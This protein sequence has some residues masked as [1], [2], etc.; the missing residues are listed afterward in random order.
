M[1]EIF[2]NRIM[3]ADHDGHQSIQGYR[4]IDNHQ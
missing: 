4:G 2:F 1:R 3:E